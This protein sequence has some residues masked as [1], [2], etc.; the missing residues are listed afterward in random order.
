[1]N[2]LTKI[3]ILFSIVLLQSTL[4]LSQDEKYRPPM[5]FGSEEEYIEYRISS[6]NDIRIIT[7]SNQVFTGKIFTMTDSSLAICKFNSCYDWRTKPV[8]TFD[9][10][11][12][13]NLVVMKKGQVVKGAAIGFLIGAAIGGILGYSEASGCTGFCVIDPGVLAAFTGILVGIPFAII[14]GITGTGANREENYRINGSYNTFWNLHKKIGNEA[15]F[16]ELPKN[17][18]IQD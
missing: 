8:L 17:I 4:L 1:M 9:Y 15:I 3:T 5:S 16:S 7:F 10:S 18:L 13:N 14:G 11:E 12:I 2:K 6:I